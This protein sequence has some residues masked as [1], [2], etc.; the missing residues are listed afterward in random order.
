MRLPIQFALTYPDRLPAL[1]APL[2]LASCGQLTFGELDRRRF[3]AAFLAL[4][5]GRRGGSYP[6]VMNAA[7]EVAVE[8]F[9]GGLIRFDQIPD[10]VEQ[11]LERHVPY[12]EPDLEEVCAADAWARE[13]A[14]KIAACAR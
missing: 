2:N 10:L 5:A 12:R 3:R 1:T 6:A 14:R 8:L 13:I 7:D 11:V 4:E 9:L